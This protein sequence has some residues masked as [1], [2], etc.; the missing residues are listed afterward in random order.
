L[1]YPT[2]GPDDEPSAEAILKE[3]NGYT[4]SE[5]HQLASFQA[6]KDDGS[7]AC[8]CWIYT[9]VYPAH[10]HNQAR[11]RQ[12]DGPEGPGT[13]LGWAFAWPANRRILYNRASADIDGRPWSARKQYVW[14]DEDQH[15]WVGHDHVDFT[16]D[17]APTYTP[18]WAQEPQGMAAL[19]GKSPFIMISDGKCSLFVPSGIKDGPLPTHYEP[20][21]SPI[22]NPLYTQQDNPAAKKWARDDN[23]YHDVADPRYPYIMTT[24]RLTEHHAGGMPTRMVPSTTAL[25]P[26]QSHWL[27]M[28]D[29]CKHCSPAPCLE[30]CPTGALFRTEFDTV[31][32]QQDICNGC[33][34]CVPACPFGVIETH[35]PDGKAHKSTL[36]YDRLKGGLEPGVINDLW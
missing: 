2:S 15:Q 36:C 26:F 28:S 4:W 32:V 14:W 11:S 3:I 33:G 35:V 30:A 1:G 29:V 16:P 17:K 31:V 7:T 34:Y 18:D 24:Y 9:G 6:L 10:D 5:R 27:M 8:G 25:Q 13:H 22:Q 23:P 20:V 19:D 21:E 12:P